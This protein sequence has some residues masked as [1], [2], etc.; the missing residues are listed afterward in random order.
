MS[1]RRAA[2]AVRMQVQFAKCSA[3]GK[4][5]LSLVGPEASAHERCVK[6]STADTCNHIKSVK[7]YSDCFEVRTVFYKI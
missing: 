7:L 4:A 6:P 3:T 1:V 2:A 5:G